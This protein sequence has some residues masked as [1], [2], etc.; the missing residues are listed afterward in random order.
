MN[1]GGYSAPVLFLDGFGPY[2]LCTG[3]W[4]PDSE[5]RAKFRLILELG[6]LIVV[7]PLGRFLRVALGPAVRRRG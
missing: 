1:A 3:L 5:L 4:W 6:C 7:G 2:S